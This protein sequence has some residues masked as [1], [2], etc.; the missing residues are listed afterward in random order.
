MAFRKVDKPKTKAILIRVSDEEKTAIEERA[1]DCKL[2]ASEYILRSALGKQTRTR[3]DVS[4]INQLI[5]LGETIRETYHSEKPRSADELQ[6]VLEAVV[7][8]IDRIGKEGVK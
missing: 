4:V 5:V 3:H 2:T 7:R 1:E 6:P 8:A